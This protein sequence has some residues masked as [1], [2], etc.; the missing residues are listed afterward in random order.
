MRIHSRIV[1]VV[2]EGT[3]FMT[4]L[5]LFS[6]SDFAQI[7]FTCLHPFFVNIG[8][9]GAVLYIEINKKSV[10]SAV[11][12]VNMCKSPGIARLQANSGWNIPVE[13]V[14]RPLDKWM[15]MHIHRFGKAI[16]QQS[17]DKLFTDVHIFIRFR[18][19]KSG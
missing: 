9:G 7:I 13:T 14:R 3:A 10:V 4:M 19:W 5:T 17:V 6:K 12:G 16:R 1:M 11:G 18:L 8:V 15:V 2:L